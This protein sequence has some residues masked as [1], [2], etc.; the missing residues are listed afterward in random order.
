MS[1]RQN[2]GLLLD[3]LTV[4]VPLEIMRLAGA[5]P[6][7]RAALAARLGMPRYATKPRTPE[8]HAEQAAID[9]LPDKGH[10]LGNADAMLFGGEGAGRSLAA[11]AKALAVLAY[12]YGGVRFGPLA[13]CA[14]HPRQRWEERDK[15]CPACLRGEIAAKEAAA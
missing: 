14:A 11:W 10:P 1:G 3:T 4:A 7:E 13:W 12:H 5:T 15:V 6:E 2:D 8:R 9:A